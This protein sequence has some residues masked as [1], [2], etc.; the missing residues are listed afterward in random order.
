MKRRK[1]KE[2]SSGKNYKIEKDAAFVSRNKCPE[3]FE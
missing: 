1:T 2:T 3:F